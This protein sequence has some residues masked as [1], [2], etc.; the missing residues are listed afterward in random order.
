MW[1]SL[2]R[3]A[4]YQ[5]FLRKEPNI[6]GIADHGKMAYNVH[7]CEDIALKS[8]IF[9]RVQ[10]IKRRWVELRAPVM[11]RAMETLRIS[12]DQVSRIS[13]ITAS[14]FRRV[15]CFCFTIEQRSSASEPGFPLF[16]CFVDFQVEQSEHKV[17]KIGVGKESEYWHWLI[18]IMKSG[19]VTCLCFGQLSCVPYMSLGHLRVSCWYQK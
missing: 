1:I 3:S 15:L 5:Y 14:I 12:T 2:V 10:W 9:Y 6:S 11:Y 16:S 17:V 4:I 19:T 13:V 7:V 8:W 18:M